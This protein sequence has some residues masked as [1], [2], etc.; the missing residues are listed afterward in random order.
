MASAAASEPEVG[1]PKPAA[2]GGN[3][4]GPKPISP[5]PPPPS[6]TCGPDGDTH[7]AM[8]TD[9]LFPDGLLGTLIG[10]IG[11]SSATVKNSGA[12]I[13]GS[14]CVIDVDDKTKGPLFRTINDK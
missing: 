6:G 5:G 1:N 13:I 14:Y 7:V 4:G 9:A 10:K 2:E 8:S 12:F 3:K 11:G